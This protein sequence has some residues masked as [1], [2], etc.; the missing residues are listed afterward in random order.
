MDFVLAVALPLVVVAG[1][2]VVV[3]FLALKA[4]AVLLAVSI[5]TL[6]L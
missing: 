5:F 2:V 3:D 1:F 6:W 4:G